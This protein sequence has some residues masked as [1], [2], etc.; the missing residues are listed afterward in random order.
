MNDEQILSEA[1]HKLSIDSTQV[2]TWRVYRGHT[3]LH[4][5]ATDYVALVVDKG[6]KGCPKFIVPLADLGMPEQPVEAAEAEF[7]PPPVAVR[8]SR[9]AKKLAAEHD[10][11][12]ALVPSAKPGTI[13]V[14]DV[15]RHLANAEAP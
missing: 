3:T 11:D 4:H 5:D 9:A 8:V 12:L 15:R 1:C 10:L 13:A 7:T 2:K 6:I 14:R